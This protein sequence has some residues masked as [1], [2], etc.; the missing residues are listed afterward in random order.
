MAHYVYNLCNSEG[1]PIYVGYT[2]NPRRRM[3]EHRKSKPW[4]GEVVT[5]ELKRFTSKASA[6]REEAMAIQFGE[7]LKN[8]ALHSGIFQAAFEDARTG[9]HY[10]LL[11]LREV[12]IG[13]I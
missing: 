13:D 8:V 12:P 9:T 7:G 3:S 4:F 10:P 5:V 6:L 2:N 1:R 11:E